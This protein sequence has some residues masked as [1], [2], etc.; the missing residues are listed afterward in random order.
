M[1]KIDFE[2]LRDKLANAKLQLREQKAQGSGKHNHR[3]FFFYHIL[4]FET[5]QVCP[6]ADAPP[7]PLKK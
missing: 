6:L 2:K 5:I 7:P 3:Y 4:I 1:A